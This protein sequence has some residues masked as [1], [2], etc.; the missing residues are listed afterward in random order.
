MR[1]LWYRF[2]DWLKSAAG[3]TTRYGV[4]ANAGTEERHGFVTESEAHGWA[5]ARAF[6]SYEVFAYDTRTM[7]VPALHRASSRPPGQG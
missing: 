3:V 4:S 7:A 5:T 2:L 1:A 6:E